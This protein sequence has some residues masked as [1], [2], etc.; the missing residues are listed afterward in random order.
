MAPLSSLYLIFEA[1]LTENWREKKEK[2]CDFIYLFIPS[3][4][5]AA[6]STC[7]WCFIASRPHCPSANLPTV[8]MP[9]GVGCGGG[10]VVLQGGGSVGLTGLIIS[11]IAATVATAEPAVCQG[12]G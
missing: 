12:V 6:V 7:F 3:P 4:P 10:T 8:P 5:P 9:L 1:G 2:D 11:V